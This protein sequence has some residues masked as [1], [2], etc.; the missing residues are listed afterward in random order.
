LGESKKAQ[1]Q[2]PFSLEFMKEV[3]SLIGELAVELSEGMPNGYEDFE[4]LMKNTLIQGLN[5]TLNNRIP[6][7]FLNSIIELQLAKMKDLYLQFKQNV[8]IF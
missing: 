8:F 5:Q 7:P 1:P 4:N 6:P 2:L 3:K